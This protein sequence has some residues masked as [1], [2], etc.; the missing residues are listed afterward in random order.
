MPVLAHSDMQT[1][2]SQCLEYVLRMYVITKHA[3][4]EVVGL[5]GI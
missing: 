3:R 2:N 1:C 5:V 4:E